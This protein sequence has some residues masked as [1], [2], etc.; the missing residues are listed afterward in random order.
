MQMMVKPKKRILD[1]RT[2]ITGLTAESFE[3]RTAVFWR[4]VSA[5]LSARL[6][7]LLS[8][9]PERKSTTCDA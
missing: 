7:L 1:Y 3:V 9:L 6:I 8:L 2:H 5:G 4:S